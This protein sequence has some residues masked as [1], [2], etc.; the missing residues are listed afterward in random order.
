MELPKI[1][2]VDDHVVEPAHVWQTWLPEKYREKGPRIER[3][4]WGAFSH[5][6]GAKYVNTEDPDGLWGDAWYFE[7]RLIYVHKRFVAIPLEA[8]PD[9]DLSKF[10]RSKMVMEALTYDEMRPGC[11][12]RD[13]R[14]KDFERNWV[15]GSLPF[16]TFP[17]FCGQTF[18]EA[19]D[20]EL[21]LACVKAYNDWMVEEWCAPSNGM[22]IPLCLMPLVGRRAR[23]RRRSSATPTAACARSASASSPTT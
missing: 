18:Y 13:E 17:R 5:K 15:D 8:T 19:D 2:S 23:G 6:P 7:D 1:I 21:G 14:I 22:N 3:K 9:G 12:D 16:P 11:Y 20:K 10:D 4:R